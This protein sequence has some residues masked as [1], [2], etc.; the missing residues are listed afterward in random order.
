MRGP[1]RA[2]SFG[3]NAEEIV[4]YAN[5]ADVKFREVTGMEWGVKGNDGHAFTSPVGLFRKNAFGLQD[6][7]G[8]SMQ[9]CSDVFAAY[10]HG[11]VI[12][13]VGPAAKGGN[14]FRVLRGGCCAQRTDLRPVGEPQ[15]RRAERRRHGGWLPPRGRGAVSCWA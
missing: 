13:P 7:H 3:D 8:N 12:D 2:Y 15:E 10:P 14:V 5:V 6:M 1:R 11:A 4:K 9:W